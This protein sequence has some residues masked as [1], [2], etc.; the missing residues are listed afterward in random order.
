[1]S[2]SRLKGSKKM[3]GGHRLLSSMVHQMQSGR[4]DLI[5]HLN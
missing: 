3:G 2:V 5:Y 1:M 4:A